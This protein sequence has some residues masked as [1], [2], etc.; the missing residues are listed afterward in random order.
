MNFF[1]DLPIASRPHRLIAIGGA[2]ALVA[3]YACSSSTPPG[4]GQDAGADRAI[5]QCTATQTCVGYPSFGDWVCLQKCGGF[6][7]S[8]CP[9]GM[10]CTSESGCC[11]GTACSARV[12]FVC[13]PRPDGG[14]DAS[15]DGP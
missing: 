15:A 1:A 13:E 3:V 8:D 5:P 10:I 14:G 4:N 12:N 6:D 2:V 9:S 7:A 11:T